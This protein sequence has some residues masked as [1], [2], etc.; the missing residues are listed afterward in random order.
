V[1]RHS[2]DWQLFRVL[3][4][5]TDDMRVGASRK[6]LQKISWRSPRQV[7]QSLLIANLI[8]VIKSSS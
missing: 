3:A 4:E 6:I 7:D 2:D 8:V 1:S 5:P